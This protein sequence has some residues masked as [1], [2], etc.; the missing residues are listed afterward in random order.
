[1]KVEDSMATRAEGLL[2]CISEGCITMTDWSESCRTFSKASIRSFCLV[3]CSWC[4]CCLVLAECIRS[5]LSASSPACLYGAITDANLHCARPQR[6]ALLGR[7]Q[8]CQD[9]Y[10]NHSMLL[11]KYVTLLFLSRRP[12]G[13]NVQICSNS[14]KIS[15]AVLSYHE[16]SPRVHIIWVLHAFQLLVTSTPRGIASSPRNREKASKGI[17]S[18]S[19]DQNQVA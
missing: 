16:R 4:T 19:N 10:W 11:V 6:I 12:K 8:L 1:M 15:V 3:G 5:P 13:G 2:Q 17:Q 7:N 14:N 18:P 9:C